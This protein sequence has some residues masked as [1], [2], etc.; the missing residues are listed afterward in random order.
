M[1]L[2]ESIVK[3]VSGLDMAA[4]WR[5]D[6]VTIEKLLTC[7]KRGGP[8]GKDAGLKPCLPASYGFRDGFEVPVAFGAG[9]A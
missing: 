4:I 7:L 8:G 9:M 2:I 5:G 1:V 3:R 6:D